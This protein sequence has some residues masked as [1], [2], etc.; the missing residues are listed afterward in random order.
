MTSS[1]FLQP[2]TVFGPGL[3]D[4]FVSTSHRESYGSHFLS[5]I[6]VGAYTICHYGEISVS[7]AIPNGSPSPTSSAFSCI[8][9][10]LVSCIHCFITIC[11]MFTNNNFFSL[12]F[13]FVYFF[14]FFANISGSIEDA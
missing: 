10:V 8:P 11:L 4:S 13:F 5:Q 9:F 2:K 6:L 14:T 12:F 3:G 7:C 1:F